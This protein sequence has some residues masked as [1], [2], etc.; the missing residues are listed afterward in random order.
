MRV[1][2]KRQAKAL[3]QSGL[4]TQ[5]RIFSG[6]TKCRYNLRPSWRVDYRLPLKAKNM[7][8]SGARLCMTVC[9]SKFHFPPII[10]SIEIKYNR[11]R[12]KCSIHIC[13]S[14][15]SVSCFSRQY[16]F[17]EY[18]YV[19]PKWCYARQTRAPMCDDL[20]ILIAV[21]KNNYPYRAGSN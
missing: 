15:S 13:S 16:P 1:F 18:L 3:F 5:F 17:V 12:Y 11:H 21:I 6:R 4:G 9:V 8:T 10:Y 14:L 7:F 2:T 20:A 19:L